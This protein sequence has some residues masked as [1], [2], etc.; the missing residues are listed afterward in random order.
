MND[1]GEMEAVEQR[2][3]Q[4]R[5]RRN[6]LFGLLVVGLVLFGL[7][8]GAMHLLLKPTIFRIAVGPA[9]SDDQKLIQVIAET[10]DRT[11]GSIRLAPIVTAGS[12]ESLALLGNQKADLAVARGDLDMPRS[13]EMVAIMRKDFAVLWAASGL[14]KKTKTQRIKSLDDLEGRRVGIVGRSPANLALLRVIFTASGVA[15]D[16]VAVKQFA[17]T[18]IEEMARDTAIDAFM[19]VGPMESKVTLDAITA[20]TRARGEPY[21]LPVDVSEAIAEHNPVYQSEEIPGSM[22]NASP[23]WPGDKLETISV[24][25][26]IVASKTLSEAHVGALTR[27]ILAIRHSVARELP[28]AA[29]IK[30]P[31]TDKDAALPVHVGAAAYVDGN[32]RTFLDRYGDYVWFALLIASGIGSAFAWMRKF[33]MHDESDEHAVIRDSIVAL[34][35]RARRVD[36]ASDFAELDREADA[37]FSRMIVGYDEGAIDDDDLSILNLLLQ[38]FHHVIAMRHRSTDVAQASRSATVDILR[39]VQ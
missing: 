30:K 16:K 33:V 7:A 5:K 39:G 28:G 12:V 23:A 17:T 29:L 20:T 2:A 3:G 36:I 32:E 9:G 11:G 37:L 6:S 38:Q 15:A 10:F 4:R 34:T 22:I 27:Q 8:A 18:E 25:H 14:T 1:T 21:F 19:A 24:S 13:A 26:L 35:S 31:D